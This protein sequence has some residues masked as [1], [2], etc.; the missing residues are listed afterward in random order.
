VAERARPAPE[1]WRALV[2]RELIGPA[3][4]H[5]HR[6]TTGPSPRSWSGAKAIDEPSATATVAAEVVHLHDQCIPLR[7]PRTCR[8]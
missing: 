1:G 8:R 5:G 2:W 3:L 7:P 4:R 6:Q